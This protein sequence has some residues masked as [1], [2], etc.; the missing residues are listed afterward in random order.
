MISNQGVGEKVEW[1]GG[2]GEWME[3]GNLL[4]RLLRMTS[5][6]NQIKATPDTKT[7]SAPFSVPSLRPQ[8]TNAQIFNRHRKLKTEN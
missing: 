1:Y 3:V 2:G 6:W 7:K 4:S 8:P 5:L